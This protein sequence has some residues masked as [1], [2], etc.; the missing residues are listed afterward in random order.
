MWVLAR[1]GMRNDPL[2]P[3]WLSSWY[4]IDHFKSFHKCG[5]GWH[6][7]ISTGNC[8]ILWS[9]K[10]TL[11][12]Q[13]T[14]THGLQKT[15]LC[16]IIIK[17]LL[18]WHLSKGGRNNNIV[19]N[20]L[21]FICFGLLTPVNLLS[22]LFIGSMIDFVKMILFVQFFAWCH[23]CL[24]FKTDQWIMHLLENVRIRVCMLSTQIRPR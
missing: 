15:V 18:A 5:L 20:V 22:I 12:R 3:S 16:L 8:E 7:A 24:R 17:C 2:P 10:K 4:C 14:S 1:E 21:A 19:V 6:F 23:V 11:L 13:F 9:W